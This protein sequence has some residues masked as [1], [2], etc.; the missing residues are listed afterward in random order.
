MNITP[1]S[2][3][4]HI[5]SL[6]Q[7]SQ[8]STRL[9]QALL[10]IFSPQ[11]LSRADLDRLLYWVGVL[12]SAPAGLDSKSSQTPAPWS[13]LDYSAPGRPLVRPEELL[14]I[15]GFQDL[16]LDWI[17]DM[18]TV[19]GQP[20]RINLNFASQEAALAL[21]PE[22]EP[23]WDRITAVRQKAGLTHPNQLLTE[24]G[25]EMATYQEILEYLSWEP[26]HLEIQVES[27]EG[28]WYKR[29]RYIVQLDPVNP[30]AKPQVMAKDILQTRQ[31]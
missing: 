6:L 9:Q 8:D 3:K 4:L 11:D 5:N 7:R 13:S 23:Y 29:Y 20:G 25:L 21:I 30:G 26:T 12:D 31:Q 19:W 2:A 22:L 15:P 18:F 28:S 14:L 16:P 17:R 24:I 1:C 27:Q 10:E